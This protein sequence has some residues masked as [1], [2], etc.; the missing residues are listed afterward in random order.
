[1]AKKDTHNATVQTSG[2]NANP[3]KREKTEMMPS[4]PALLESL[5]GKPQ[6]K[7]LKRCSIK[8]KQFVTMET[9]IQEL[10]SGSDSNYDITDKTG[11]N[12]LLLK[13]YHTQTMGS[14]L[15]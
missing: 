6:L 5:A 7:K 13:K 2:K 10:E 8:Q 15:K 12:F 1:M 14:D 11:S 4:D 3:R 9:Q